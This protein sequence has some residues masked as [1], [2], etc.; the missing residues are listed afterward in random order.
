MPVM[1]T[2]CARRLTA[3]SA[4]CPPPVRTRIPCG[5][6]KFA[7]KERFRVPDAVPLAANVCG[8]GWQGE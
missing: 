1:L 6:P 3:A 8:R 7:A 5:H 4:S 2:C